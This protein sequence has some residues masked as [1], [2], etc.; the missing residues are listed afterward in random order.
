MRRAL[1]LTDDCRRHSFLASLPPHVRLADEE[2]EAVAQPY[3]RKRLTRR[4]WRDI[5]AAYCG[6][7]VAVTAF[8]S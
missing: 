5:F 8:F 3:W 7:F 2:A 4:D 6:A 1:V